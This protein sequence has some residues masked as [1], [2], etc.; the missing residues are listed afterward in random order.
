MEKVE[1]QT[2]DAILSDIRMPGMDGPAFYRALKKVN[3]ELISALAFI[4]GDT[5]SPHVK[6]FLEISERP[7]LEKPLMP[8]E[9][10]ELVELLIRRQ[11]E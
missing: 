4:T 9:I 11:R 10:R 5:L 7:Y 3:P 2:Y 6:E 8:N 1:Q